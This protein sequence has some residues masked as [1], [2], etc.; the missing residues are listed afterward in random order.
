MQD[1]V[2]V[3][4][5]P[6]SDLRILRIAISGAPHLPGVYT[7]YDKNGRILYIGKAVNIFRRLSSHLTNRGDKRHQLLL[8]KAESVDWMITE[9]E[10]SALIL[11]A[12]LIRLHKPPLNVE[13]RDSTRYPYLE[14]TLDEDFPRLNFT[15]NID[16][17]RLIPRFGPYPEARTL[18]KLMN[19]LLEVYPLRR[20]KGVRTR[21]RNRK[22]CLMGQMER[23][24]APCTG[25]K[26][27][28]LDYRKNT[29]N[30]L[31]TLKGDWDGTRK[32]IS[33][34]MER[35]SEE[36]NY[37][38]AAR[39]R[40][41]INRL[42]D[43]GWPPYVRLGDRK[44]RDI[45]VVRENWGLIL[46]MRSSRIMNTVRL[47]FNRRWPITSEKERISVLLKS[48][49]SETDDIPREIIVSHSPSDEDILIQWL[50]KKRG[51]NIDLIRP[52]RGKK[53]KLIEL[54]L[55]DL[56][57]FLVRLSWNRPVSGKKKMLKALEG[58]VQPLGLVKKPE[59]IIAIDASMIQGSFP[60]AA[61]VSFRN[62]KPDRRGYRR[63]LMQEKYGRNDPMMIGCGVERFLNHLDDY[64]DIP[65]IFLI[66]G[67]ITQLRSAIFH[68]GK[69]VEKILFV[70]IAKSEEIL[71]VGKN[72]KKL[73]L[74]RDEP[75]L[76]L[77]RRIRDEAHR[78]VLRYHRML[79][80]KRGIRSLLDDAPGIGPSTRGLLLR[81]FGSVEQLT[82]ASEE[83]IISIP[84]IGRKK[85]RILLKWL[86]N[87]KN[88]KLFP[89]KEQMI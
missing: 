46:Q 61:I 10:I 76:A 49:Y 80:S 82:I 59:W 60:V 79:R 73:K 12:D 13:M 44:S 6:V 45:V 86:N 48:Y 42:D 37:E 56:D 85:A 47:P 30:I 54:A 88:K 50:K 84:G 65:D 18:R 74:P 81:K 51:R 9:N 41:L 89:E 58:L 15:R 32:R 4:I 19:F 16:H 3:N 39:W 26:S 78:F 7:F 22:P 87:G 64:D 27:A 72:E 52:V 1:A 8:E 36:K 38:E 20:C 21:S 2:K 28:F 35:A 69:W 11:E 63:F 77:L 71:F 75:P 83:E 43:F 17:S 24:P 68:A 66:D 40:D 23:C 5:S 53:R 62:G 29:E 14:L 25:S 33:T 70:S 67:G 57:Q 55:K 31:K 34:K